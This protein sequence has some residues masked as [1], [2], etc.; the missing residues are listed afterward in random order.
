MP[1]AAQDV[2]KL[3]PSDEHRAAWRQGD[4]AP[5]AQNRIR[6]VDCKAK[7]RGIEET[8]EGFEIRLPRWGSIILDVGFYHTEAR[9]WWEERAMN[10]GR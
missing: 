8:E 7:I 9:K 2:L 10:E 1:A 4:L 3:A 5:G 6:I